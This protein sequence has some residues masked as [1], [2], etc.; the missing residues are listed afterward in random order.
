MGEV[1]PLHPDDEF[2]R[3]EV[4]E[5]RAVARRSERALVDI[6]QRLKDIVL[7]LRDMR[8]DLRTERDRTDQL[9]RDMV[10][11]RKLLAELPARRRVKK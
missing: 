11:H 5:W 2:D 4:D 7:I 8:A 9:E 6:D 3:S 1:V 10:E